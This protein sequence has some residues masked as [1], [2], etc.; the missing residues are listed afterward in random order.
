MCRHTPKSATRIAER[1]VGTK[2]SSDCTNY[3]K[4][5]KP[6]DYKGPNPNPYV[7]EH[8]DLINS[9]RSGNPLNEGEQ[10]ALSTMTAIGGR[11]A[12]YTGREVSWKWLMEGS[13]LDIFPK[14]PAPGPGLFTPV[15]IPGSVPLV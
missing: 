13:K 11:M 1:V 3:I 2:G 8:T 9:I 6:F 15:P 4:G 7:V 12:A 14:N 5:E 10:V